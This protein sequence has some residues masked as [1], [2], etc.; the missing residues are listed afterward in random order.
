MFLV[1]RFERECSN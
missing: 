1:N